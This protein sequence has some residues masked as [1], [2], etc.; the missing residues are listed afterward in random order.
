M[1][2]NELFRTLRKS[3]DQSNISKLSR[4]CRLS[5]QALYNLF[6]NQNPNLNSLLKVAE[7]LG[8]SLVLKNDEK[9]SLNSVLASLK[10]LG[11]PIIT[12]FELVDLLSLEDTIA[13]GCFY[14]R[15]DGLTSSVLPYVLADI[16]NN[17]SCPVLLTLLS[18]IKELRSFGYFADLAYRH[19]GKKLLSYLSDVLHN[20]QYKLEPLS[21]DDKLNEPL[22]NAYKFV[23]NASA[24]R[25][26]FVTTD[27]LD[28]HLQRYKK[29][30][31]QKKA[32]NERKNRHPKVA[33]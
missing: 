5:R 9:P 33:S 20:G 17:V 25:F 3:F 4:N 21:R 16:I 23:E 19:S 24:K 7:N 10:K 18:E 28:T 2:K 6:E 11:A 26:S 30:D 31:L 13:Y 1:S 29:W 32:R 27:D 22:L 14:A 12:K 15:Q 8:F